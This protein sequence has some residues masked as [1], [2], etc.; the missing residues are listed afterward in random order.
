MTDCL[1]FRPVG[2]HIVPEHFTHAGYIR[3]TP[4]QKSSSFKCSHTRLGCK[5]VSVNDD[6]GVKGISLYIVNPDIIREILQDL[7]HHLTS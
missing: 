4:A 3:T 1:S 5:I 2:R 6:A 7:C